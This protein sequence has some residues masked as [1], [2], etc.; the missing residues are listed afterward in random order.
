MLVYDCD[1]NEQFARLEE[2]VEG[3]NLLD[4][5]MLQSFSP[6]TVEEARNRGFRSAST[7]DSS[8]VA[9]HAEPESDL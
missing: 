1:D 4:R 6:D 7:T 2:R 9:G 3:E 8:T 5:L